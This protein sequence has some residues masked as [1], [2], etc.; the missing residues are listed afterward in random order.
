[1]AKCRHEDPIRNGVGGRGDVGTA[2]VRVGEGSFKESVQISFM[3]PA[4]PLSSRS[5]G[6]PQSVAGQWS[7][8]GE[9]TATGS[10]IAADHKAGPQDDGS[11]GG[12]NASLEFLFPSLGDEGGESISKRR[13]FGAGELRGIA[14]DMSGTHLDPEG[15]WRRKGP[16]GDSEEVGRFDSGPQ[17]FVLMIRGFDAVNTSAHEIDEGGGAVELFA[18]AIKRAAIPANVVPGTGDSG[19][20]A[21]D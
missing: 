11:L 10:L 19:G 8:S 4:H 18:P 21:G 20:L 17:N 7:Q 1:M 2:H 14:V 9:R 5:D 16:H 12:E 13:V 15:R 6:S 3:D